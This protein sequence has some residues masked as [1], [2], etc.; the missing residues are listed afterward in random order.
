MHQTWSGIYVWLI[1]CGLVGARAQAG[2]GRGAPCNSDQ[3]CNGASCKLIGDAGDPCFASVAKSCTPGLF[4]FGGTCQSLKN[5]GETCGAGTPGCKQD[6]FCDDK[7]EAVPIC[8]NWNAIARGGKCDPDNGSHKWCTDTNNWSGEGNNYCDADTGLCTAR[9]P[10]GQ[11]CADFNGCAEAC[12]RRVC[13][14]YCDQ[15]CTMRL[16]VGE[17][18]SQGRQCQGFGAGGPPGDNTYC[19]HGICRVES[20]EGGPCARDQ[21]CDSSKGGAKPGLATHGGPR[22]L[23]TPYSGRG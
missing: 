6:V 18:C 23:L 17:A 11:T 14:I 22:G 15:Q 8:K 12:D 13:D 5:A 7:N 3:W 10:V 16:P 2:C 9:K 21:H 20:D 19:I 1:F 4:C